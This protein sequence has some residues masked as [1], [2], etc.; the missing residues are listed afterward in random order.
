MARSGTTSP[1]ISRSPIW[2]LAVR[3]HQEGSSVPQVCA[4]LFGANLGLTPRGICFPAYS[5][6]TRP[7]A[8]HLTICRAIEDEQCQR[9]GGGHKAANS[10]FLLFL[11]REP[12]SFYAGPKSGPRTSCEERNDNRPSVGPIAPIRDPA[13]SY[14]PLL[15]PLDPHTATKSLG[16]K[17]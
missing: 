12:R 5:S 2:E 11:W 15:R 1:T 4:A 9:I 3:S 14:E 16:E 13:S 7:H 6:A 10:R 17:P 8:P